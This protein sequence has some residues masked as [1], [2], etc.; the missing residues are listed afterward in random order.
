MSSLA[1]DFTYTVTPATEYNPLK[2]SYTFSSSS[3][4]PLTLSYFN[5]GGKAD[6]IRLL[7]FHGKVSFDDHRFE[8][9]QFREAKEVR[10]QAGGK[11]RQTQ[12]STYSHN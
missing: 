10:G 8:R 3:S 5:F 9:H 12:H 6:T 1:S 4:P 11:R 2:V 7:A